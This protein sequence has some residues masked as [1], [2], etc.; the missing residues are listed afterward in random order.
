MWRHQSLSC[1][2]VPSSKPGAFLSVKIVR[3]ANLKC[4]CSTDRAAISENVRLNLCLLGRWGGCQLDESSVIISATTNGINMYQP[5][6]LKEG[7]GSGTEMNKKPTM[8]PEGLA[9]VHIQFLAPVCNREA[10]IP[11]SK[12]NAAC[13]WQPFSQALMLLLQPEPSNV[14]KTRPFTV[15][16]EVMLRRCSIFI[17]CLNE[18]MA[19][20]LTPIFH[21]KSSGIFNSEWFQC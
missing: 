10:S 17:T 11:S 1:N 12:S 16:T 3:R 19:T 5:L 15:F 7:L 13:H 2:P 4:C 6:P 8:A 14:A 18:S 20:S 21:S 9:P